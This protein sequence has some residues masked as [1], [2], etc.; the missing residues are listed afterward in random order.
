MWSSRVTRVL[1]DV[2]RIFGLH[3]SIGIGDVLQKTSWSVGHGIHIL[4]KAVIL[5]EINIP[6]PVP[7]LLHEVF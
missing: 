5:P 7:Y 2:P 3:K 4:L 6:I 1:G